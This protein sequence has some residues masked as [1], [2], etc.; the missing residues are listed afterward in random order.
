M[1]TTAKEITFETWVFPESNDNGIIASVYEHN[2]IV[3]SNFFIIRN[4]DGRILISG[5]GTD[6]L[7][8][9]TSIPINTWS[10][11]AIVFSNVGAQSTRIY[12][13]G[14]LDESGGLNYNENNGGQNLLLGQFRGDGLFRYFD[15]RLDEV[16]IWNGPRT[17]AEIANN[18]SLELIGNEPDLLAYY[19]FN[20]GIPGGDNTAITSIA[21][22]SGNGHNGT[23][24]NFEK[25]GLS[26]RGLSFDGVDDYI[27]LPDSN[28]LYQSGDFTYEFWMWVSDFDSFRG[29]IGK[30]DPSTDQPAP[31]DFYL[32]NGLGIPR[33][34]MGNGITSDV[35]NATLAP[36]LNQWA[37]IAV[38][39]NGTTITHYLNGVPNGT[40]TITTAI[41]DNNMPLHIGSRTNLDILL[42]GGM[43]ELRIWDD[44]R[45]S[46]EIMDHM[47]LDLT[48]TESGLV[49]YFPFDRANTIIEVV[50]DKSL[51]ENNGRPR[52]F[53]Y[54]NNSSNWTYGAPINGQ[55]SDLDGTADICDLCTGDDRTGDYNM[56]GICDNLDPE[57]QG[58]VTID[59]TTYDGT[60]TI[61]SNQIITTM[62]SVTVGSTADVTYK[63]KQGVNL[64]PNFEVKEGG[65]FQVITEDCEHDSS[66]DN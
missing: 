33:V 50:K 23:I 22:Q 16:R 1:P 54:P 13:N 47:N 58:D 32:D 28:G 41:A 43:E 59:A 21:D 4:P 27:V 6:V 9:Q 38:V 52:N 24:I 26:S 63:A 42:K 57:C 36:P 34:L 49:G 20:E 2:S 39:K 19:P 17:A 48:G 5:N 64:N 65:V 29:L 14:V 46:T 66:S 53:S 35:V 3:N 30:T 15:G 56:D 37:H 8:S 31:F 40:G 44:A 60:I 61:V 18:M 11:I 62:G 51:T 7:L 25:G 12:I 45:T 55:D 10:H